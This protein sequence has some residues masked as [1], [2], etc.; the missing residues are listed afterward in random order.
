MRLSANF[1][2]RKRLCNFYWRLS[3]PNFVATPRALESEEQCCE[4]VCLK[5]T[6]SL[7][8]LPLVLVLLSARLVNGRPAE[9]EFERGQKRETSSGQKSHYLRSGRPGS[10]MARKLLL[11]PLRRGAAS[12]TATAAAPQS[13]GSRLRVVIVP[14]VAVCLAVSF[15]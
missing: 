5:A 8:L 15:A 9:L 11:L 7:L 6:Y 3:S 1:G 13:R 14:W 4:V 12:A 2:W 10:F